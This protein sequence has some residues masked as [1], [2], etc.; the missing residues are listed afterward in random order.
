MHFYAINQNCCIIEIIINASSL[1]GQ[2]EYQWFRNMDLRHCHDCQFLNYYVNLKYATLHRI[3]Q[4]LLS[5]SSLSSLSSLCVN[6]CCIFCRDK[7]QS[8]VGKNMN[9]G[10]SFRCQL[11]SVVSTQKIALLLKVVPL[12]VQKTGCYVSRVQ[13]AKSRHNGIKT[14]GS[15]IT[16]L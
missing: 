5:A 14:R 10:I 2:S 3:N 15:Y 16:V 9:N 1:Y 12:H 6:C 8:K 11:L 13:S 7:D 4:T